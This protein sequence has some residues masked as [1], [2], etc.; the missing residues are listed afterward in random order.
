M[1]FTSNKSGQEFLVETRDVVLDLESSVLPGEGVFQISLGKQ[2]ENV[3]E[4]ILQE[5]MVTG[6][7]TTAGVPDYDYFLLQIPGWYQVVSSKTE[8]GIPLFVSGSRTIREY[9]N[10]TIKPDSTA[11]IH[12][13]DLAVQ[14][15]RPDRKIATATDYTRVTAVFRVISRKPL[16]PIRRR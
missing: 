7:P 16:G 1:S 3:H 4:I 11:P 8:S 9:A 10:R 13:K 14:V 15:R 12:F 2:F 6:V 5:Y